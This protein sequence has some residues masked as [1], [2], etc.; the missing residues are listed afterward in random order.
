MVPALLQ[1]TEGAWRTSGVYTGSVCKQR[2]PASCIPAGCLLSWG[3]PWVLSEAAWWAEL[4]EG[5]ICVLW[6]LEHV[7]MNGVLPASHPEILKVGGLHKSCEPL[8]LEGNVILCAQED[9]GADSS[10]SQFSQGP[11]GC[12]T[13]PCGTCGS[14]W[15]SLEFSREAEAG[16]HPTSDWAEQCHAYARGKVGC[17]HSKKKNVAFHLCKGQF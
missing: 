7:D 13:G 9:H 8:G 3:T 12:K 1:A 5:C 16:G 11:R 10:S 6:G 17:K 4:G 2:S 14:R 15:R